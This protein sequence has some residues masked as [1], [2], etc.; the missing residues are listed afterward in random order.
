M[1]RKQIKHICCIGCPRDGFTYLQSVNGCYKV[2]TAKR[3]WESA[4][5]YCRSLHNAHLLV[6][7]DAR[8]QAAVAGMLESMSQFMFSCFGC[9]L[10]PT[11]EHRINGDTCLNREIA[12]FGPSQNM[13]KLKILTK[14]FATVDQV[15]QATSVPGWWLLDKCVKYNKNVFY[16]FISYT[17]NRTLQ[18][19]FRLLSSCVVCRRHVVVCETSAL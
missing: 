1:L 15:S 7:N 18:C 5:Y 2:I 14:T 6:I 3:D 12:N 9:A 8:E 19:N 10:A 11:S 17:F 16:L 13:K 4:G